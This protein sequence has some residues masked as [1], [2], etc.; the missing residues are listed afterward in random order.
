VNMEGLNVAMQIYWEASQSKGPMP[1]PAKYVD[2]SFIKE[3]MK[4]LGSR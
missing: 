4:E 1:N 3:A 2:Q